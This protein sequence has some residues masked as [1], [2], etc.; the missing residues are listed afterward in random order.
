MKLSYR[1]QEREIKR[2]NEKMRL[3][4]ASSIKVAEELTSVM[5]KKELAVLMLESVNEKAAFGH[6]TKQTDL[7]EAIQSIQRAKELA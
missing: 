6:I 7:E 3:I 4:Q 5:A 1:D 2:L